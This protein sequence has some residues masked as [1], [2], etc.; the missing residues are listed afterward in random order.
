M[1]N[2]K[3]IW[4]SLDNKALVFSSF[5]FL[6]GLTYWQSVLLPFISDDYGTLLI[7]QQYDAWPVI[8]SIFSFDD[9]I[10]HRPLGRLYFF[11]LYLLFGDN[12]IYC[13]LLSLM[14]HAFNTYLVFIVFSRLLNNKLSGYFSA[15]LYG[16]SF[17]VHIWP[18]AWGVGIFDLGGM[19]FF[20]L[21]IYFYMRSNFITSALCYLAGCLFKEA[22][23][24]TPLILVAHYFL[25]YQNRELKLLS[26][27]KLFSPYFA[28]GLIVFFIKIQ[29]ISAFTLPPEHP[30]ASSLWGMHIIS[31]FLFYCSVLI[32][33]VSPFFNIGSYEFII[34]C[35]FLS[36]LFFLKIL[37]DDG[38]E[39]YQY[40]K[41][42]FFMLLWL[43]ISLLPPLFMLDHTYN[44]YSIYTLPA[45][46][47]LIILL[48]K[49]ANHKRLLALIVVIIAISNVLFANR[50]YADEFTSIKNKDNVIIKKA[51]ETSAI[52]NGLK[53]YA[54]AIP[55]NASIVITGALFNIKPESIQ[56]FYNDETVQVYNGNDSQLIIRDGMPYLIYRQ[57]ELKINPTNLFI[58]KM[59]NGEL[60]RITLPQN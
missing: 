35:S 32:N 42:I 26:P 9:T 16:T 13:H 56:F 31:N 36:I 22:T 49:S 17:K 19:L 59:E 23:I 12:P 43:I 3:Y 21:T 60:V 15:L 52:L 44:Y 25:I 7:F 5:L 57:G 40:K 37:S 1:L 50:I 41:L 8:K 34:I 10:F 28:V 30:Y 53:K 4:I 20:L 29:G 51:H 48:C 46:I 38:R 54:P 33:S 27:L 2:K 6:I 55:K 47:S 18:L 14:I 39:G 58:F 24:I 45:F 11:A